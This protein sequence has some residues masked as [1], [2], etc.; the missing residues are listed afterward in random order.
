MQFKELSRSQCAKHVMR[1]EKV[2]GE[3]KINFDTIHFA[4][5]IYFCAMLDMSRFEEPARLS[6]TDQ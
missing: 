4:E 2:K 1:L 5:F 3:S 6:L